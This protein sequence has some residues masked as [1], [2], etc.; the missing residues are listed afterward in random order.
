MSKTSSNHILLLTW[1]TS[2]FQ[3]RTFGIREKP[4]NWSFI[5]IGG[6]YGQMKV[7]QIVI[8]ADG[9]GRF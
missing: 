6:E 8:L 7:L 4:R 9:H 2:K 1:C 5:T 3:D